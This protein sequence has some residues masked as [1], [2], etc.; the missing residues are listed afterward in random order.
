MKVETKYGIDDVVY[1]PAK[2]VNYTIARVRDNKPTIR[3]GVVLTS[4]AVTDDDYVG[5]DYF[6]I[7]EDDL[8]EY[9]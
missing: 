9:H 4:R 7:D 2:I 5:T 8:Q 1:I 6:E 3:Y